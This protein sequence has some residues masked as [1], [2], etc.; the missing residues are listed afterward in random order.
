MNNINEILSMSVEHVTSS[1]KTTTKNSTDKYSALYADIHNAKGSYSVS[2][3][4]ITTELTHS[5][6]TFAPGHLPALYEQWLFFKMK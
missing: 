6:A 1:Q 2:S 4:A 3:P 5:V